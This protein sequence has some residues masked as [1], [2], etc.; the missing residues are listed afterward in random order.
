MTIVRFTFTFGFAITV[1]INV[2]DCN[3]LPKPMQCP[4]MAPPGIFL[5]LVKVKN[6]F[7]VRIQNKFFRNFALVLISAVDPFPPLLLFRNSS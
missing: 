5:A 7:W 4:R 6:T 3:V 2:T 1:W